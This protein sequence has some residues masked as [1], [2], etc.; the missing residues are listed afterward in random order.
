[1]SVVKTEQIVGL[2]QCMLLLYN[3]ST[4]RSFEYGMDSKNMKAEYD[5]NNVQQKKEIGC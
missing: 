2:C 5:S 1:M 3:W 4:T